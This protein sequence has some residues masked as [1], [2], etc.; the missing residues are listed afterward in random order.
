MTPRRFMT[1]GV[2]ACALIVS[3]LGVAGSAAAA[4]STAAWQI[5]QG[6]DPTILPPGTT[7]VARYHLLITNVGGEEVPSGATVTDT[8]SAGAAPL[9]S[10]SEFPTFRRPGDVPSPCAAVGQEVTCEIEEPV[11]PGEQI[12]VYVPL[13]VEA[14]P[15]LTVSNEVTVSSAAV[16]SASNVIVS[17]TGSEPSPFAFV[18]S[19]LGLSGSAF[20]EAGATPSAG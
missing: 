7:G 13:T 10:G 8:V 4:T 20:D 19:P 3:T 6:V 11:P 14:G 15:P 12:D 18:D 1:L 17:Q 2:I 5:K 9:V 16:A